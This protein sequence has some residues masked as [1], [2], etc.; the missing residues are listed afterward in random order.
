MAIYCDVAQ[1]IAGAATGGNGC[2]GCPDP[3]TTDIGEATRGALGAS[4]GRRG[5]S[6]KWGHR[7]RVGE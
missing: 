7:W 2:A 3:T 5:S 4:H 1:S 6:R